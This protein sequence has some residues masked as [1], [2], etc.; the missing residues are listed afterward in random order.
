MS[1]TFCL[2]FDLEGIVPC[3]ARITRVGNVEDVVS[4]E[5]RLT[6]WQTAQ[7]VAGHRAARIWRSHVHVQAINQD[8]RT[9]RACITYRKYDISWQLLLDVKVVLLNNTLLEVEILRPDGSA[10]CANRRRSGENGKSG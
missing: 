1:G 2:R 4:R 8:M 5:E 3:G 7:R 10:K 6:S 9:V